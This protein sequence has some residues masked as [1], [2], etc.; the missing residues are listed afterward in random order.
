MVCLVAHWTSRWILVSCVVIVAVGYPGASA[1]STPEK[2]ILVLYSFSEHDLFD[3][4]D[5]LKSAIRDRLNSPANFYVHY[6]EAQGFEDPRF[7]ESLSENLTRELSDVKLDLVIVAAYPALRFALTYRDQIFPGVPVLFSYVDGGR[8][9]GNQSWP[10]VTGLTIAG[11]VRGTLELLFRLHPGAQNLAVITGTSEFERYWRTAVCNEFQP[12]ADKVKLIEIVGLRNDEIL[13]QAATLPVATVVLFQVTPRDSTQPEVG[14]FD[15]M[16]LISQRFPTY[17]AFS[18][19]CVGHGGIG[20][21]Y[22]DDAEQSLRTGEMA[23]RLLSGEKP[24]NIPVA[25]GSAARANVDWRQ[26]R[27]WHIPESVLPPG[28]IVLY[29]QPTV[30]ER[31]RIYILAGVVLIILQTLLIGGLLVQRAR[32][33]SATESLKKIGGLLIHAQDDERATIARELHDDFSQ[34]LALQ[35]IELTHLEHNLPESEVEERARTLN[36]L[37]ESR[38]MAADMRSLSHQLHSSRLELVGLAAALRGL[39]EDVTKNH[40][41]TVDFTEPDILPGLTKDLGLCLFRIAQEA[42]ANVVNHSQAI[43]ARIELSANANSVSLRILDTGKG[44]DPDLKNSGVG[45]G[46]ISM[47]E[48]LRL[49]GGRL[50]IRSE[51]M[52]GTEIVA[53]IP[54]STSEKESRGTHAA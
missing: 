7:G 2:N 26:L 41:L 51:N 27:R 17:C 33:K 52:R 19:Y 42:L 43:R 30:W 35:C 10:G 53:E 36:L 46:L 40:K 24:E 11:G 13:K 32:R 29:R 23:A 39:C 21:S 25:H 38:E 31:Y 20:A 15:T 12:Y 22:P 45:I 48:R 54:L 6:M 49:V 18:N 50:S 37:K 47:R 1:A 5:R 4:L 44:F 9:E 14:L 34:R 8:L 28:T 3:P 16:A